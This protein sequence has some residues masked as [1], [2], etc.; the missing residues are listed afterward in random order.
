MPKTAFDID[1]YGIDWSLRLR[2]NDTTMCVRLLSAHYV[3]TRKKNTLS[4]T[5]NTYLA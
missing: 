5:H 3:D 2:A 1:K 4:H